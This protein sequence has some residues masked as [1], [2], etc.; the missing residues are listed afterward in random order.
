MAVTAEKYK[1]AYDLIAEGAS[2][3][4][5]ATFRSFDESTAE[6]WA[7]IITYNDEGT[8]T[9]VLDLCLE[10]LEKLKHPQPASPVD[11]Y[12][13]SLQTA[14]RAWR[15]GRDDDDEI[16]VAA[17]LHDIGDFFA[18]HNH[19]DFC[20]SVLK[21]YV[22]PEVYWIVKHHE[23]FQGYHFFHH[24]GVD[25]NV[26]EKHR[27]HEFFESCRQFCDDY[28]QTAFDPNY[29]TMPLE[30]FMPALHRVLDK[31]KNDPFSAS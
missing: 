5:K 21:P 3:K 13:H 25:R 30:A 6:D 1:T 15:D 17:L 31:P 8:Q 29:N 4:K 26:R 16:I 22:R 23:L 9:Q 11:R 19:G 24:Y 2:I 27:G 10:H 12:E 7:A 20:A 14:T 18:P 28:D